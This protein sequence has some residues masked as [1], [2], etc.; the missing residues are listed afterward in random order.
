VNMA[1]GDTCGLGCGMILIDPVSYAGDGAGAI[2]E[3]SASG[4]P[5][6][7]MENSRRSLTYV[8]M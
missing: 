5:D 8:S 4:G 1:Y 7:Y 2:E 6:I 3:Y